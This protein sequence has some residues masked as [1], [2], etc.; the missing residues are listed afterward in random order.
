[1]QS[2]VSQGHVPQIKS[3]EG[4]SWEQLPVGL[5]C[6]QAEVAAHHTQAAVTK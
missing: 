4:R 6:Y 5:Q 2:T 1:L 3:R